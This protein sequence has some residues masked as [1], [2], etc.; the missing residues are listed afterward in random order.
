MRVSG[1]R[2]RGLATLFLALLLAI[3]I[4]FSQRITVRAEAA[5]KITLEADMT[6]FKTVTVGDTT[7]RMAQIRG[8]YLKEKL[9]CSKVDTKQLYLVW[10]NVDKRASS[11]NTWYTKKVYLHENPVSNYNVSGLEAHNNNLLAYM[12]TSNDKQDD[13]SG[14]KTVT[15][16]QTGIPCDASQT[17]T[18]FYYSSTVL[19][20][21]TKWIEEDR[22]TVYLSPLIDHKVDGQAKNQDYMTA[23]AWYTNQG[24]GCYWADSNYDHYTSHYN[25][26]IDLAVDKIAGQVMYRN[27]LDIYDQDTNDPAKILLDGAKE[28]SKALKKYWIGRGGSA[29]IKEDVEISI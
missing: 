11:T 7:Y 26:P 12:I 2:L 20:D 21:K 27:E 5:A 19:Q 17:E 29:E 28:P 10:V 4:F 23:W 14:K 13:T 15:P 24:S 25:V 1:I 6:S 9:G 16:S 18:L 3:P 8:K 22:F